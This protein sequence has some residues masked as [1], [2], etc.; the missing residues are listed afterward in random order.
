MTSKKHKILNM[1]KEL[2]ISRNWTN[3]HFNMWTFKLN[4]N[5]TE[6]ILNIAENIVINTKLIKLEHL[7]LYMYT[8]KTN[9]IQVS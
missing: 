5:I 6:N 4:V 8:R 1:L 2:L 3:F 9:H 7:L